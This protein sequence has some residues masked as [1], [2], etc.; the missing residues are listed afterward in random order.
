MVTVGGDLKINSKKMHSS[1][2]WLLR[3]E[4]GNDFTVPQWQRFYSSCTHS[5]QL[6]CGPYVLSLFSQSLEEHHVEVGQN[7]QGLW[8]FGLNLLFLQCNFVENYIPVSK[9]SYSTRHAAALQSN[10]CTRG[11]TT[12]F[13]YASTV[14]PKASWLVLCSKD[15]LCTPDQL[16]VLGHWAEQHHDDELL[17]M[18][19]LV[20]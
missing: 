16:R 14:H 11:P 1:R 12:L 2:A 18:Q 8:N 10:F 7:E 5:A 20:Q 4:R 6:F 17:K 9:L 13:L 19:V 15:V 3:A